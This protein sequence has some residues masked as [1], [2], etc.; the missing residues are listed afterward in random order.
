[1]TGTEAA[2]IAGVVSL[3]IDRLSQ[4]FVA[5]DKTEA[6]VRETFDSLVE[7]FKRQI[8]ELQKRVEE[9]EHER[10][11]ERQLNSI[12]RDITPAE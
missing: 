3:A 9:C 2:L 12:V 6:W 5:R 8:T 1:M 11:K 10:D 7:G 4:R